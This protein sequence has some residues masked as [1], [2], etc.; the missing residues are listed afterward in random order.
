[1][2][3]LLK[4]S[5]WVPLLLTAFVELRRIQSYPPKRS[6]YHSR[7]GF[8]TNIKLS[9]LG[10][11]SSSSLSDFM[12]CSYGERGSLT[13]IC[14]NATPKY[15]KNTM[16]KFDHLDETL[17]CVNCTLNV[18]ESNTFDLAGN[19]IRRL[20]L[21]NSHIEELNRK[22]F[23]GL[24]FMEELDLAENKIKAILNGTF[25]GTKKIHKLDLAKNQIS[26]LLNSGL[27]E[28]SNLNEL[29]LSRNSIGTI[30][31]KAF[32]GLENLKN[33][34]L[35]YNYII[36]INNSLDNLT[37]LENL[38]LRHNNIHKFMGQEFQSL[39]K[40]T[41][42]VLSDN[43]LNNEFSINLKP[44]NML[45]LLDLSY[46]NI[47]TLWFSH[48][49]LDS[50]EILDLSYN[51]I[52]FIRRMS[53]GTMHNLRALLLDHNKLKEFNTGQWVGFSQLTLLTLSR[54][55]IE[56]VS[57]TGVY[58]L[59]NL[60][61]LILSHNNLT[62]LDYTLLISRLPSLSQLNL[63]GNMLPCSLEEEMKRDFI[64]DNFKFVLTDNSTV[65][66]KC[67]NISVLKSPHR[68][69]NDPHIFDDSTKASDVVL[70]V[71]LSLMIAAIGV[72]FYVQFLF[73][74]GVRISF[75]TR[76]ESNMNLIHPDDEHEQ[77][78]E[79]FENVISFILIYFFVISLLNHLESVCGRTVVHFIRIVL[80]LLL[81]RLTGKMTFNCFWVPIWLLILSHHSRADS[82]SVLA[83]H[84]L[85]KCTYGERGS[86]TATCYNATPKYFKT[87]LYKFDHLDETLKCVNCIL[88]IIDSNTFDLSGNHIIYLD[89][90]NSQIESLRPKAF[91]GLI[92]LLELNL[93]S[94]KI[95]AIHPGTFTG[96]KKICTI[97]LSYNEIITL[98][99]SEFKELENLSQLNLNRNQIKIIDEKAFS[100]LQNLKYLDLSYNFIDVI[101]IS[102]YNLTKLNTLSLKHNKIQ[103]VTGFEF[104]NLSNLEELDLS[105]NLLDDNFSIHLNP[106]NVLRQLDLSYN[107]INTLWFTYGYLNRLELLDL[108]H[109]NISKINKSSF[110]AL[111]SLRFLHLQN[112][113][114]KIVATGQL[115]G[116]SQLQFLN[117][118][119]NLIEQVAI[120]GVFSVQNLNTLDLSHNFL[121][122]LD[123][124]ALTARL[125]SL[126]YLKLEDNVLPCSLEKEMNRDFAED[127][128]KYVLVDNVVGS[129]VCMNTSVV[130]SHQRF[131]T[132]SYIQDD[133][134]TVS[135][136]IMFVIMSLVLM[137]I[138]VLFYVQFLF[139]KGLQISFPTRVEST[140]NLIEADNEQEDDG[141]ERIIEP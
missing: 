45:R 130:K 139:Y 116:F 6:I 127:N 84:D 57:I 103:K 62:N 110:Q 87:T 38:N 74:K 107:K 123:Y 39:T 25:N 36:S 119:Y 11:Y 137:A 111:Y 59:Q 27:A 81:R 7:I 129:F 31:E 48:E 14:Y 94:N 16:Y 122:N 98:L 21:R 132:D 72:L 2:K 64:E 4:L 24:I 90:K 120:T 125:P 52:S 41:K 68:F 71:I 66:F 26:V 44:G 101:N 91:M 13:A 10:Q 115:S 50:L 12:K 114:L 100:G 55:S 93:S 118:S 113:K 1:M 17:K 79:V 141:L 49:N 89:L 117:C 61:I 80:G 131:L 102:L 8:D 97:D 58:S 5:F 75:P 136:I 112:N 33:L 9:S 133:S 34:D 140:M 88:T 86:L 76:L 128:F 35:S 18:I 22:A 19:Q 56:Q 67:T 3:S 51:N 37:S 92:F 47:S 126:S 77:S 65:E 43:N 78:D 85:M 138:G 135:D 134:L 42:L 53:L 15:F 32:D 40:L 106:E 46:T 99:D 60:Q 73:Y 121:N 83:S 105:E 82:S 104:H 70:F 69:L 30:E 29:I 54:N 108:S 23:M 28:L 63:E 95:K 20:D 124:M 96:T 109:N